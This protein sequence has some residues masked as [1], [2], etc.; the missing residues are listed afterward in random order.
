MGSHAGLGR[1]QVH[2]WT[3]LGGQCFLSR[4]ELGQLLGATEAHWA[5][6]PTRKAITRGLAAAPIPSYSHLRAHSLFQGSAVLWV[7]MWA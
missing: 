6:L 3:V 2:V 4:T 7:L 5:P 1:V